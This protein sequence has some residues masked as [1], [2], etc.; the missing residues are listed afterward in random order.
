MGHREKMRALLLLSV[1]AHASVWGNPKQAQDTIPKC[2]HPET[3]LRIE[4]N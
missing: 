3:I 4:R 2:K 1:F